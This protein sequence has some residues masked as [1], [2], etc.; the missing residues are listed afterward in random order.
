[1]ETKTEAPPLV[2]DLDGTLVRSDLLVESGFACLADHPFRIFGMARALARGKSALKAEIARHVSI[3]AGSLPYDERVLALAREARTQGRKVY[4][5]SASNQRYVAAVAA[6]IDADGWFASDAT[7]NL[8]GEA[9]ARRLTEEFGDKGFDYVGDGRADLAVWQVCRKGWC[10]H[11]SA[12]VRREIAARGLDVTA[13]APEGSTLKPWIKLI[14][15]HQWAKNAL[16]LVPLLTAHKFAF[17]ALAQSLA[18]FF[19]FSFAASAVYIVNDLVDLEADRKHPSKRGRPLA[20][21]TAPILMAIP[22]AAALLV[23]AFALALTTTP[24][25]VGVLAGYLALTTAYSFFLKRKMLV[26]VVTL[27]GLYTARVIGGAA[28]IDVPLSEWLLAFSMFIFAAL[29]LI[30]RYVELAARVDADLPDPTNRNYR[31]FDL[32][33]VAALAAAAGFNAVTVFALYVSSDAVRGLYRH[34]RA[35]WLVCPILMYWLT[36]ALMMAHRRQMDDD[37]ISFALKDR[38]SLLAIALVG[39]IMVGAA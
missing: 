17:G 25:F 11:P 5:A 12:A 34:P 33:I 23:L 24:L 29:A 28:A 16:V 30:K 36:R 1:M 20:A 35:L 13:I 22:V 14:R 15:P 7:T 38:N 21:G 37:P 6:H 8:A 4:V 39:A 27:A 2:L 18:A 19:A 26:D 10:V 3:D 9:K 32:D 31:K